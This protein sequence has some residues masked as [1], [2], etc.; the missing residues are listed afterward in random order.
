MKK[1]LTLIFALALLSIACQKTEPAEPQ[2]SAP[3]I[4]FNAV[5]EAAATKGT[6]QENETS[7]YYLWRSTDVIDLSDGSNRYAA[8]V[9]KADGGKATAGFVVNSGQTIPDPAT[10]KFAS[11]PRRGA[12]EVSAVQVKYSANYTNYVGSVFTPMLAVMP[13]GIVSENGVYNYGDVLFKHVGGLVKLELTNMPAGVS[14]VIFTA[15]GG[16]RINGVVEVNLP[17]TE[18]S[19]LD[20]SWKKGNWAGSSVAT[21]TLKDMTA[22]GASETIYIPLPA[23]VK[24]TTAGFKVEL[25]SAAGALLG[26]KT[27]PFKK[28][29]TV[30][31]A[32]MLRGVRYDCSQDVGASPACMVKFT[33]SG[34]TEYFNVAV[35]DKFNSS[36]WYVFRVN[37]YIDHSE[38]N[39]MDLWRI[40]GCDR[41][42]YSNGTMTTNLSGLLTTGESESVFKDYGTSISDKTSGYDTYDFTG[43]FHGDE[44]IDL[45][46]DCGITFYMDDK[47]VTGSKLGSSFGWT[48]CSKFH[49]VQKSNI[50]KTALKVNGAAQINSSHPVIAKHTKTTTFT[51]GGYCTE[52]DFTMQAALDMYWYHG[53]CCIGTCVAVEGTNED[54]TPVVTFDQSGPNRLENKGKREYNAWNTTNKIDV[55]V[56]STLTAGGDDS[57]CRMFVWDT[58]NYAKYYRRFPT[59][60]HKSVKGEVLSS[61]MDV[62]FSAR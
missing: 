60:V 29:Y 35:R 15:L 57:D 32:K 42:T 45:A 27:F 47:A 28:E 43:G 33:K 53:I 48:D 61:V 11:Y 18:A 3:F 38:L 7:A 12:T 1:H 24:F 44:R 40:D 52:N 30:G 13:E 17:L 31:R 39:Y 62:R 55:R 23:G 25:K 36:T 22:A 59:G 51:A 5:A 26:S 54:Y 2:T 34:S 16:V 8:T 10:L 6:L 56:T 37:H 21:F 49:Y 46:S 9:N 41:A 50:H 4:V 58:K 14:K 20:G 19:I